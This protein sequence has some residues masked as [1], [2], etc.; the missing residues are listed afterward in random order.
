MVAGVKLVRDL[1][2]PV[3][4]KDLRQLALRCMDG[5][6]TKIPTT[7]LSHHHREVLVYISD[8]EYDDLLHHG[9]CCISLCFIMFYPYMVVVTRTACGEVYAKI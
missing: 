6:P 7:S 9:L 2:E 5:H 1:D 3:S 4:V 8:R